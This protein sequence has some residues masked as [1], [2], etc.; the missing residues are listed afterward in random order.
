[1]PHLQTLSNVGANLP[2]GYRT[3]VQNIGIH[4]NEALVD[5]NGLR[6][7]DNVTGKNKLCFLSY[8]FSIDVLSIQ[9]CPKLHDLSGL[10]NLV[11]AGTLILAELSSLTSI[12]T[13][14]SLYNVS[15]IWLYKNYVSIYS[16]SLSLSN[17]LVYIN[18]TLSLSQ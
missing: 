14:N 1:M 4:D 7:V 8:S 6:I 17:T 12:D 16:L 13:I 10:D 9:N 5:V 15:D 3:T 2:A 11:T 18:T